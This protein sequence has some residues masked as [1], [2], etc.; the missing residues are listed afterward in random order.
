MSDV[1]NNSSVNW[2]N[3]SV[4][5]DCGINARLRTSRTLKNPGTRFW[6]CRKFKEGW[7]FFLW[8]DGE[9]GGR[10]RDMIQD[11]KKMNDLLEEKLMN[12]EQ[13]LDKKRKKIKMLKKQNQV[14]F[15]ALC[16]LMIFVLALIVINFMNG[17]ATKNRVKYLFDDVYSA[18]KFIE[19]SILEF[20]ANN[21]FRPKEV[22]SI[23][24]QQQQKYSVLI[25]LLLLDGF[26]GASAVVDEGSS[27]VEC[28]S[29]W[30]PCVEMTGGSLITMPEFDFLLTG[31]FGLPTPNFVLLLTLADFWTVNCSL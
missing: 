21:Y 7:N 8:M 22:H 24:F 3:S 28:G 18:M 31:N 16:T 15:S 29:L 26:G 19:M 30:E 25:L 6:S 14:Q 20:V 12:L 11:L 13:N 27:T 17:V 23:S 9:V 4:V 5:C 1:S 2:E 10:T